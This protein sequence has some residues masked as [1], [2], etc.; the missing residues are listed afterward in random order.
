MTDFTKLFTAA[1]LVAITLYACESSD[2]STNNTTRDIVFDSMPPTDIG[3][4]SEDVVDD[5]D[6]RNDDGSA[7]DQDLPDQGK[8]DAGNDAT[9]TPDGTT[10]DGTTQDTCKELADSSDTGY[11]ALEVAPDVTDIAET[12]DAGESPD[13]AGDTGYDAQND[14]VQGSPYPYTQC[15]TNAECQEIFGE[16]GNCN[17]NFPG[18]QCWGCD[19]YHLGHINCTILGKEDLTLSCTEMTPNACLFDCPCPSWL[20]CNS[21]QLCVLKTCS[22]NDE[23]TPFVCRPLSPGG[24]SYC[25][26]PE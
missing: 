13:N 17:L 24:T 6:Q 7:T 18:G 11:D 25:L 16:A 5:T 8:S 4:Q 15:T 23:C 10:Q 21:N 22:D 3:T 12:N 20:S 1:V 2:D 26:D 19:P 9:T 14:A